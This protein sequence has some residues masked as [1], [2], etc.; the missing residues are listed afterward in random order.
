M[1]INTVALRRYDGD[2]RSYCGTKVALSLDGATMT[3]DVDHGTNYDPPE[4]DMTAGLVLTFAIQQTRYVRVYSSGS[5]L[6]N[7]M[8]FVEVEVFYQDF[9]A[10]LQDN[11]PQTS[12]VPAADPCTATRM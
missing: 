7:R 9:P 2:S 8:H 4:Q 6:N 1:L 11:P 3:T 5:T 10:L 12:A